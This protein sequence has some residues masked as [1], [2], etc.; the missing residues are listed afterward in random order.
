MSNNFFWALTLGMA[1]VTFMV[2]YSFI[3]VA[4]KLQMSE[5]I[6]KTLRF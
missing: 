6:K 3:G 4:G 2:R 5:R 1:A